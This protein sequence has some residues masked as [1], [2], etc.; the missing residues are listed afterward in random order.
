MPLKV[1]GSTWHFAHSNTRCEFRCHPSLFKAQGK[2]SDPIFR[3]FRGMSSKA[4]VTRGISSRKRPSKEGDFN[5]LGAV[6]ELE[7]SGGAAPLACVLSLELGLLVRI[8]SRVRFLFESKL[9]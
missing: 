9:R 2:P 6:A 7:K 5:T 4:M 3:I 8:L 1:G